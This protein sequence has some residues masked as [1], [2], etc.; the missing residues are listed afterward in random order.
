MVT[1]KRVL[2]RWWDGKHSRE[3]S[4]SYDLAVSIASEQSNRKETP[5]V[6]IELTPEKFIFYEDGIEVF[7]SF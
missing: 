5:E 3:V 6:I 4:C 1:E 2:V 7:K